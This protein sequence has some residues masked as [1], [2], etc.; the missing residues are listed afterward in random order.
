MSRSSEQTSRAVKQL[1][2]L[3]RAEAKCQGAM[4]NS[5]TKAFSLAKILPSATP[6]VSKAKFIS[7]PTQLVR[8]LLAASM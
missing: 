6:E 1:L 8:S 7:L 3:F 4:T 5:N 2:S